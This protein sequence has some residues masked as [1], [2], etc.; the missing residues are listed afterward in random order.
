VVGK[1]TYQFV[2]DVFNVFN[3]QQATRFDDNF[4][5]QAGVPDPDFLKPTEYQSPRTWRLEFRCNF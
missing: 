4:K 3:E 5:L 2:A 1:I